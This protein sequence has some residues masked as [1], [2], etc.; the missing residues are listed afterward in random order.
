MLDYLL[1]PKQIT[2]RERDA[3]KK[4]EALLKALAGGDF[5]NLKKKDVE[6]LKRDEDRKALRRF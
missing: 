5:R 3:T 2:K 1:G 6:E 4:H